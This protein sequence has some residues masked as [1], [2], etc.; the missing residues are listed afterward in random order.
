ML[1]LLYSCGFKVPEP[2]AA[3][4]NIQIGTA[5]VLRKAIPFARLRGFALFKAKPY[6]IQGVSEIVEKKKNLSG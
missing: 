6:E 3:C 1:N 5:I 2:V 4:S